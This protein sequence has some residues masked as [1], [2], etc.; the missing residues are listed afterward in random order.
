MVNLP[1]N[2]TVVFPLIM[3]IVYQDF[4]VHEKFCIKWL[5][6]SLLRRFITYV[7]K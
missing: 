5:D 6:N 2:F 4:V 3:S 1:E 7:A